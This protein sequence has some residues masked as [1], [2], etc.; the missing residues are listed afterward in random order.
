MAKAKSGFFCKNCGYESP[1]WL[2]K[3]PSCGEWNQ[4]AEETRVT[5]GG[6][7]GSGGHI[8]RKGEAE[9]P[10]KLRDVDPGSAVRMPLTDTE[11]NRV[12]GG[13]LVPGS[14]VLIAGE[15]GVG[16]STLLLQTALE[17]PHGT[18]LYVSGEESREQIAQ[19]AARLGNQAS[20][21]YLLTDIDPAAV[22]TR[23]AE[24]KPHFVVV[25]SVQT[26]MTPWVESSPGS[27][28][29]IREGAAQLIR[30]AKQ[31]GTAVLMVG[32]IT[33]DGAV[34]GPKILEH[35]V[36]TV[37]IFEGDGHHV[38]RMLRCT[39]NRFGSTDELGIYRMEGSGLRPV[40]NPSQWLM[41]AS[42]GLSG[43]ATAAVL[44]GIRPLLVEV[45]ALVSTAVYGTPQRSATG[46]DGRRLNM[47]LAVLEKR[48]GF[49]L[50]ARDVFV[51]M[52]GGM[53][54][55]DPSVDLAVVAAIISSSEDLALPPGHCFA[56]EVGLSGE[57]RPVLR[58]EQRMAEAGKLGLERVYIS[59]MH[60][61][62]PKVPRGVEVMKVGRV[63]D[64]P[65]AMFG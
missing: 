24:L 9:P 47:L 1:R 40:V 18:V 36:D 65:R 53:R 23:A 6:K 43:S 31:Q 15:P 51:N 55:S 32:H 11:L 35:M 57:V 39:K 12:L 64:L 14:V 30:F 29:Q 27:L 34:A 25:D 48:C 54:L 59:A 62:L 46:F 13:G 10:V 42:G 22:A 49:K 58:I 26:L 37:A 61:D 50:G 17:Y 7:A 19:R 63:Q 45:Q 20:D 44:E 33:K 3:C 56:G 38:F 28:A 8:S 60:R 5:G 2:G 4:F 52:A 21:V 16:K 41:P